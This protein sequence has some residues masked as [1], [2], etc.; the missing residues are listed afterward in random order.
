MAWKIHLAS[1][2]KKPNILLYEL[3]PRHHVVFSNHKALVSPPPPTTT[4]M[5]RALSATPATECATPRTSEE[6]LPELYTELRHL[7]AAKL[8]HERPGQTLQPTALVHE[9]WLRIESRPHHPWNCSR[10]FFSAFAETMRRILVDNARRKLCPR[11]GGHLECRPLDPA[12]LSLASPLP[13][14]QLLAVDEAL[15]AL[16]T[17]DARAAEIVKLRFFAGLSESEIASHL[18]ISVST[19]RRNWSFARTWLFTT[20]RHDLQAPPA[21]VPDESANHS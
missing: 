4:L 5:P 10:H 16:A 21:V 17:T 9:A 3:I 8:A 13:D 20:I 1:R 7:A 6:L 19:V 14:D 12:L 11:H 2:S 18:E 15:D